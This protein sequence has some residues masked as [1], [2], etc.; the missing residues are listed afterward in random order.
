M[1]VSF[2]KAKAKADRGKTFPMEA[3][4]TKKDLAKI[5]GQSEHTVYNRIMEIREQNVRYPHAVIKDGNCLACIVFAY[6]DYAENREKIRRKELVQPYDPA[7]IR[8]ALGM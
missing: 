6:Y 3:M 7:G 2:A 4:M 8:A 1:A 5:F